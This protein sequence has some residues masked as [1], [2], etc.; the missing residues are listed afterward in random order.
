MAQ[1][2]AMAVPTVD[3]FP[4]RIRRA[5]TPIS[6]LNRRSTVFRPHRRPDL[7]L[8][9]MA[10]ALVLPLTACVP[11]PMNAFRTTETVGSDTGSQT[12]AGRNP[13]QKGAP[14]STFTQ[15][16]DI[17]IPAGSELDLG[18]SL[19]LGTEEGW[20]GRLSLDVRHGMTD[21]YS[22][23][24]REMPKF[25]WEQLTTV[26]SRISTMTYRRGSRVATI[27]L[28]SR[29][30]ISSGTSIDFTV[31]PANRTVMEN[32]GVRRGG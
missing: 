29:S 1:Y 25:S 17:P 11:N 27:T 22:F 30:G 15:F 6:P 19:V 21:M 3:A 18:Q 13:D 16:N 23:Y 4:K 7:R 14:A 26:R 32:G 24:E 28:Q 12:T 10:L 20:I 2:L 8:G 9:A 31:A 5:M